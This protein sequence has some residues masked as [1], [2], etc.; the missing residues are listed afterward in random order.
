VRTNERFDYR[1]LI[2]DDDAGFRE[3]VVDVLSPHF[4]TLDVASGEAAIDIVQH[5]RVD[6]VLFDLHMPTL[7]GLRALQLVKSV[8]AGLPCVMMS[9]DWT[10][11]L[12]NQAMEAECHSVL[13]KPMTRVE[14][15]S[16]VSTALGE[17]YDDSTL[18]HLVW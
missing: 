16:T 14:L 8:R 17:A 5:D 7:T 1:L 2:A 13:D 12:R 11:E 4:A 18:G 6:L 10:I 9:A 15:L 3:T